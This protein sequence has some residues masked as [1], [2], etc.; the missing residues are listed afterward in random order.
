[1]R[2]KLCFDMNTVHCLL[3]HNFSLEKTDKNLFLSMSTKD[4]KKN[5]SDI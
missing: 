2:V 4:S 1:M 3:H 5:T